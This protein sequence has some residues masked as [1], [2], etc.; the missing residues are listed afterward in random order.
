[1]GVN[2]SDRI[3]EFLKFLICCNSHHLPPE[4]DIE[5]VDEFPRTNKRRAT[6]K[7]SNASLHISSDEWRSTSCSIRRSTIIEGSG[8]ESISENFAQEVIN[9]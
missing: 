9:V 6:R 3:L 5:F 8:L 4:G 2:I 1:M 7:R